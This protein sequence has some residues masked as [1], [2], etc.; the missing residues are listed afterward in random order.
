VR[1]VH[2]IV[3]ER[4]Y[5][6]SK[7]K[8]SFVSVT[9]SGPVVSRRRTAFWGLATAALIAAVIAAPG[10]VAAWSS[11]GHVV[12]SNL[13][14]HVQAGFEQWVLTGT[15]G[16]ELSDAVAFWAV[17]HVVKAVL[18]IALLSALVVFGCRVWSHAAR[19][20]SGG[21]RVGWGA[22]GVLGAGLPVLALL[23]VLAN[24]QGAVS[25]LSSV[26]TFLPGDATPAVAQVQAQLAA[27]TP[28]AVTAALLHDFRTY[29][30][31]LVTCL[32]VTILGVISTA[33]ALL[34]R[35][36]RRPRED[37]RT[38]GVLLAG[39]LLVPALL[40]PLGLLLLA[41]LSTT[42]DTAPALAAFFAGGGL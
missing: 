13:G 21:A 16:A 12:M 11:A 8:E 38:R 22:L 40:P 1:A 31:V 4:A 18:A 28:D 26:L 35:R 42:A 24:I 27:G 19:S 29:H 3:A 9:Y 41:N 14:A 7:R 30:A 23:V 34:V 36:A 25:P 15:S 10:A 39:A 17:F 32:A 5:G 33:I 6:S 20:P 37:R 2:S